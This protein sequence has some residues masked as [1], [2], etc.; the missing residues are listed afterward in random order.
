LT[1]RLLTFFKYPSGQNRQKTVFCQ[2]Y[3]PAFLT[4]LPTGILFKKYWYFGVLYKNI[5]NIKVQNNDDTFKPA[6]KIICQN[7]FLFHY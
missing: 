5:I 4:I 7:I 6:E 3:T 2:K 1:E